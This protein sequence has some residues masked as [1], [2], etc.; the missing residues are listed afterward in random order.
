ME[1]VTLSFLINNTVISSLRRWEHYKNLVL[2]PSVFRC[3]TQCTQGF[4]HNAIDVG[5]V[6]PGRQILSTTI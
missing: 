2:D 3:W 6:S 1:M 5:T 4:G